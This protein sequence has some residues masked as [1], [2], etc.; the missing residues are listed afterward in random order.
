MQPYRHISL[1]RCLCCNAPSPIRGNVFY[2]DPYHA[3]FEF[4][5]TKRIRASRCW[6][7]QSYLASSLGYIKNISRV[8]CNYSTIIT[9]AEKD[10]GH[11]DTHVESR[12]LKTS[13][14]QV[15]YFSGIIAKYNEKSYGVF[16]KTR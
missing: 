8:S 5:F 1:S 4:Y 15:P 9:I 2:L 16:F 14:T 3:A 7:P 10:F 11:G 12:D 6:Q 13:R